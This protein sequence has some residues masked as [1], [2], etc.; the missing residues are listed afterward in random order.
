M[1][2]LA[3][4]LPILIARFYISAGVIVD[5][6][7]ARRTALDQIAIDNARVNYR[8]RQPSDEQTPAPDL[9]ILGIESKRP[10]TFLGRPR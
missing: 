8:T 1:S 3:I 10:K 2:E 4:H 7:P 9:N 6:N 5:G